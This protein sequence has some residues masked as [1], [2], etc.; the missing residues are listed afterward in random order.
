[1]YVAGKTKLPPLPRNVHRDKRYGVH[2]R[3]YLGRVDG[4]IKWGKRKKL[5]P[6]D[7]SPAE[8]KAA[9]RKIKADAWKARH[10]N[11]KEFLDQR[12]NAKKRGIPFLF[13]YEE[14][15][16]WWGEDINK[17]GCNAGDLV[18]ARHGDVGPYQLGNVYKSTVED[19]C[20]KRW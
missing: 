5:A 18:M 14:W 9:L 1:M 11:R 10:P 17:R 20:G 3:E 7:A 8:I 19:N 12:A 4:K 6:Y 13:T 16:E 15:L 2:Y